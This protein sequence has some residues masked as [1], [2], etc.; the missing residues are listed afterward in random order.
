MRVY[1]FCERAKAIDVV[2]FE[3]VGGASNNETTP[4]KEP[5]GFQLRLQSLVHGANICTSTYNPSFKF[6]AV[7]D[8]AGMVS[9]VDLSKPA[10]LWLQV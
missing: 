10:L 8:R 7:S 4:V 9:L 5:P 6:V 3:S 2:H 1:Q